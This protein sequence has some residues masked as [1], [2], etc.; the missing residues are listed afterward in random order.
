MTSEL[1]KTAYASSLIFVA[2]E[3][4]K[5]VEIVQSLMNSYGGG[6]VVPAWVSGDYDTLYIVRLTSANGIITATFERSTEGLNG[7]PASCP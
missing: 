7:L 1:T 3:H 6:E 2:W 4:L 5:L